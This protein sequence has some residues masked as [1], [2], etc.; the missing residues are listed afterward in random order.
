M[1][2]QDSESHITA[3]SSF[4]GLLNTSTLGLGAGTPYTVSKHAVTLTMEA[5][6][7][8]LRNIPDCKVQ[9]HMLCPAAVASNVSLSS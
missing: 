8:E 2:A 3:T 7:H 1:L 6:A 5:M 9:A 4:A